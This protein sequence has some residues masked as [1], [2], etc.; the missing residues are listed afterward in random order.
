M[1][2]WAEMLDTLMRE[3]GRALFGYAYVLTG[4]ADAAEDL[5]QDALV[6]AFKRGRGPESLD[7]AHAYVKR[8]IQTAA[9]DEHRRAAVRPARDG[10]QADRVVPDPTTA[11]STRTALRE[12]I[13]SLPPRPR[14]CLVMRYVDGMSAV[15]IGEELGIGAATV[16]KYLSEAVATLQRTHGDFGLD[17]GDVL[18]GGGDHTTVIVTGGSR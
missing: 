1:S 7:A 3:R 4:S 12:A 11:S 15:A 17:P 5:M 13:L 10:R 16:R 9:I 18:D 6:R 8:A 14:T 2:R